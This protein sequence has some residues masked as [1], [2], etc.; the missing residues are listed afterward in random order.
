MNNTIYCD[1]C[2]REFLSTSGFTRHL[3]YSLA[4]NS[5]FELNAQIEITESVSKKRNKIL[6]ANKSVFIYDINTSTSKSDSDNN[7]NSKYIPIWDSYVIDSHL[8]PFRDSE[9]D[10]DL[11]FIDNSISTTIRYNNLYHNTCTLTEYDYPTIEE[12]VT[13]NDNDT[14]DENTVASFYS[15]DSDDDSIDSQNSCEIYSNDL[16]Q[17]GCYGMQ[18]KEELFSIELL[19]L[20][21]DSDSPN[22]VYDEVMTLVNKYLSLGMKEIPSTFSYRKNAIKHFSRRFHMDSL[23]PRLSSITFKQKRFPLVT[24]KAEDMVMSLLE[25]KMNL[26]NDNNLIFPTLDGTPFGKLNDKCNFI[27]DIHTSKAYH[28]AYRKLQTNKEKDL[29]IGTIFYFDKITLDKH[30]HLSLDPVQFTLSIFNRKTRNK[31]IAWKPFGYIPNISLH[32]KAESKHSFKAEDKARFTHLIIENI[33]SE[34]KKLETTGIQ[35]YEFSFRGKKY[36]ANLKFFVLVIL[37]DTESHDKLCAHYNCRNLLVQCI[38]RHCRVPSHELDNPYANYK[39][40]TQD[41]IDELVTKNDFE[42]LKRMSQYKFHTVWWSLNI[43][44]GGNP[45]GIHGVT[46]SEPLHMIDLGIFKYLV[47]TFF[48]SIG[49]EGCKLH[50]LM[51]SW[52]KRV[53]RN[54]QHQSDK[55][56]PR[57]YYPNGISGSN[58]LNGHEYVGVLLVIFILL[59]MEGPKNTLLEY[60]VNLDMIEGWASIFEICLCWRK[61]LQRDEISKKELKQSIVAHQELLALI[62]QFADRTD[63]NQWKIIKF[64]MITHI[65][66]SMNDF[67]VASNFD[68]SAP[69]SNHKYNVKKPASHTQSRASTIEIQTATRYY[70]NMVISMASQKLLSRTKNGK[71][72]DNMKLRKTMYGTKF[73]ITSGGTNHFSDV[74]N[75]VTISWN[76]KDLKSTYDNKYITWIGK[77]LLSQ[78]GTNTSISGCTEYH[79]DDLIFRAHPNYKGTGP[80]FDWAM[81]KWELE[82]GDTIDIPGQIVM[83]L[84]IPGLNEPIEMDERSSIQEE[85]LYALVESCS[86]AMPHVSNCNRIYELKDKKVITVKKRRK[87]HEVSDKCLYLVSVD[88]INNA[89]A[90]VPNLGSKEFDFIVLRP[91]TE[92]HKG[93][94]HYIEECI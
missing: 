5:I 85:G 28:R 30:G 50:S 13:N 68:T 39:L 61:W 51:D 71:H 54:L 88:T 18:T 19:N 79:R 8:Q 12:I 36:I 94:T 75:H 33:L 82:D 7:N 25:D 56:L 63:G 77:H 6:P 16:F 32:S 15:C 58:K 48:I 3:S 44:F 59:K 37:G 2:E 90:S 65:V 41:F 78:L 57:T 43:N 11:L 69:E 38:C 74:C 23:K 9:S 46:P 86:T 17:D 35:N 53:G 4:C 29:P 31:S 83:F 91:S 26:F 93:F 27:G 1:A 84:W 73:E 24:W 10:N 42:E 34:Y 64:H 70:E 87:Y 60:G 81:F 20:M 80:W 62:V 49:N 89:I 92:W 76:L 21:K 72:T 14:I 55:N 52:A 66:S 45:R 22:Y 40:T 47:E 67:G